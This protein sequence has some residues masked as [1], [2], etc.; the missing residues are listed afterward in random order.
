MS[1][2]DTVMWW[3]GKG[4]VRDGFERALNGAIPP[5]HGNDA[6]EP[7][8]LAEHTAEHEALCRIGSHTDAVALLGGLIGGDD[9][10][11]DIDER[12]R[13]VRYGMPMFL[14]AALHGGGALIPDGETPRQF[15]EVAALHATILRELAEMIGAGPLVEAHLPEI[16]EAPDAAALL[17]AVKGQHDAILELCEAFDRLRRAE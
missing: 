3:D 1:G 9:L 11:A 13:R 2:E 15:R 5:V 16:P 7:P 14:N 10:E 4:S 17:A 12:V 8:F 6:P